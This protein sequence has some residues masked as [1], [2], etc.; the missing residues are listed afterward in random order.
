MTYKDLYTDLVLSGKLDHADELRDAVDDIIS[1]YADYIKANAD[2]CIDD[3]TI[4]VIAPQCDPKFRRR[5]VEL[6]D[7]YMTAL[8]DIYRGIMLDEVHFLK[9]GARDLT[10]IRREK[11]N[12]LLDELEALL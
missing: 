6:T 12:A 3:D 8:Q 10:G 11:I 1:E 2:V 4:Y 5:D 7:D 9:Q